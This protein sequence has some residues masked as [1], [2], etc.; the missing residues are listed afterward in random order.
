MSYG[1]LIIEDELILAKKVA[2]YLTLKNFDVQVAH[3]GQD[4]LD[5]MA[6]FFPEAIIL[7]YNLPGNLNGLQVLEKI[8]AF[9]SAIKVILMTGQG[10]V[11]LAVDAIKAGAYDYL[12]KPVVLSEL[13]LLLEKAMMQ[14]QSESQL[15][16]FHEKEATRSGIDQIIGNSA[17][18]RQ[19][20]SKIRR[21]IEATAGLQSDSPPAIL[22]FGETGTGKELVARALHFSGVRA[23]KPFI[24]LNLSAIPSHLLESELFG[25]EKGAFT[26]ARER[27]LGLVEAANGGTLFLDE[28]GELDLTAQVKLLKLLEDRSVRRLGSIRD[29]SVDIQV[30]TA[31][32]RSLEDMVM[33]G[34]F[35]QDLFYRLNTLS[36]EVPSLRE[37]DNDTL[38]L[39]N[40]FITLFSRKYN[41]P[42]VTLDDKARELIAGYPWPGNIRELRNVMEQTLLHCQGSVI[43]PE[44]LSIIQLRKSSSSTSRVSQVSSATENFSSAPNVAPPLVQ[45]AQPEDRLADAERDLI[46]Q[47][48]KEVNNN[49]SETARRL[50][51]TRDRL[52]YRLKKYNYNA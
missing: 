41:K 3:N 38:V 9:D 37:R 22:V 34:G 32:N 36:I 21:I 40:H 30:I 12:S 10:N 2:K 51:I 6:E 19:L 35:R 17:S 24:E 42:E 25:F 1:V 45:N 43:S 39:A 46:I 14:N 20:K 4:G 7:D 44:Q 47:T 8:K 29:Y 5:Q 48:M 18:I 31:T 13:K 26:D 15:S 28:I 23:D 16:Y 49:I 50:G 27:K 52:R 11:R 33:D